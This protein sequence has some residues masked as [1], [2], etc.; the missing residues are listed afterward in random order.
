MGTTITINTHGKAFYFNAMSQLNAQGNASSTEDDI[1]RALAGLW[2]HVRAEGEL[3]ELVMPVIGTGR[4]R[5]NKSRKKIISIIAESFIKASSEEKFTGR[6]IIVVRP[7]DADNFAVNLYEIKD[8]LNQ[9]L[10]SYY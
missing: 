10:D 8:H 1:Q 4:G 6:L 3:Q 9:I 5:V 2:K 7:E